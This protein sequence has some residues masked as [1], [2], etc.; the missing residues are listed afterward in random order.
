MI[1]SATSLMVASWLNEPGSPW[2]AIFMPAPTSFVVESEA[3]V[4]IGA[5]EPDFLAPYQSS[6]A[7]FCA[8]V[9]D[10]MEN[11]LCSHT[12]VATNARNTM[13]ITPFMVKKA[14]LRRRRSWG[15][16]RE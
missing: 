1:A 11:Y 12:S 5:C 8:I 2:M 9:S 10:D 4:A 7:D 14:A 13:A 6:I 16:T 3:G 15:E